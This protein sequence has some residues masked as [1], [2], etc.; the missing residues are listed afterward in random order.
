M[1]IRVEKR[2]E[3]TIVTIDRPEARNA[4]SPQM[5][6]ELFKAF[7]AF[8]R[9]ED[10][11]VAVLTGVPGAFC[12]GFDLKFAAQGVDEKWFAEHDLDSGFDGHDDQPHKGPMGPTRLLL[13]KPVIAAVS[14]PA[15]AGG[16]ELALW[17]DLRVMERSSYM[18]VYCRRWGVPLIDGGTVRLPRIVGHGRAMEL[19]LT[20]RKIEA[21]ECLTI[22]LANRL[23]EDGAALETALELATELARFPQACMRADRLSAIRQWSLDVPAAL[24]NE[25]KS[26][27]TFRAEGVAGAAR[28]A[29]GKGRSGDFGEI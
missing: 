26:A 16:M 12:A 4:V 5:A 18:G 11:K 10:S 3:I 15:V 29:G 2:G 21:E 9:D 27:E 17:C 28:F 8:D 20:G 23:T 13:S 25:W 24:V 7:I 19:I 22:G 14:G 6:D 1:T